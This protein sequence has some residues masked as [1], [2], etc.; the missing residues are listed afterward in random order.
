V[1]TNAELEKMVDTSDAWIVERT[2]IRERRILDDSRANSDLA[3]EAAR[4]AC[5]Q[6]DLD[7]SRLDAIIVATVTPDVPTPA[8]AVYVQEKLGAGAC[9][10]FDISAACAGFVYGLGIAD[11]MI[12]RGPWSN[13]M[14]VGCEILSR[15]VDWNDRTTCVLFGDGAG[16]ALVTK[17]EEGAGQ[18]LVDVEMCADGTQA[19]NL[20]IPGG[21]SREPITHELVERRRQFVRMNGRQ[22]FAHAVK[23]MAAAARTVLERNN[24]GIEDVDVVFAHQANARILEGVSQRSGIPM[25]RFFNN[26]ERYGN[27]SS[28]SIPVAMSEALEHGRLRRGDRALLTA[29]GAGFAWGAALVEW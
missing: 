28:A 20:E 1:L 23:N 15:V 6:A 12:K 16:A 8:T 5:A 4:V 10:A 11:S 9:A 27:T 13:V 3:A 26:I 2:G 19:A 21:G 17:C 25:E 24:R 22:V 29:L 14:V 7:P 18:Q